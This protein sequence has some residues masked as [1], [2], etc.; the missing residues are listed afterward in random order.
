[1]VDVSGR[2]LRAVDVVCAPTVARFH[3][4]ICKALGVSCEGE[5]G[6]P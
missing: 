4:R 1:M 5:Y 2:S 3:E 6:V